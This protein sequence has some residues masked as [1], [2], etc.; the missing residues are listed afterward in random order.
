MRRVALFAFSLVGLFD[1]IYLWWAYSTPSRPLVCLG[2]GCDVVRASRFAYIRGVPLPLFGFAMYAALALLIF[3]EPLVSRALGSAVRLAVGVISGGGVLVSAYLTWVEA[4]VL[5]AWCFWCVISGVTIAGIFALAVLQVLRPPLEADFSAVV[6]TTRW[7]LAVFLLGM[8]AGVPGFR[9]LSRHE[10]PA[11]TALNTAALAERL[12]R[13]DSHAF[14]NPNA[15]LTVTEFADFECPYC[16]RA[17][18]AAAAVRKRFA[19]SV[20]FVFRQFPLGAIHPQAERAAEASECAAEQGKFW[21]AV[22]KLYAQQ[23]DLSEAALERYA[24]EL[25]LDSQRFNTCLASGRMAA[26][27]R[28]DREDALAIGVRATPT[29]FIGEREFEGPLEAAQF[30][31]LIEQELASRGV[32]VRA[33]GGSPGA[34]Q[35]SP[36]GGASTDP[37]GAGFSLAVTNPAG[38]FSQV[39]SS[40]LGCSEAE[41]K[42]QQP[43]LIHTA[44]ARQL[45]ESGPKALF[46]DVRSAKNFSAGRIP[47]AVSL[48]IEDLE[49]HWETLPKD[50]AIVI[51]ESGLSPG[52]VCASARAA[53]RLLLAHGYAQ[54]RVKVYQEGLAGWAKANLPIER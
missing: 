22:D 7:F 41:A 39:S 25:G 17:E 3:S 52:D 16:S 8:L 6:V 15:A 45:F 26:L 29:F 48:P 31:Q 36:R 50:R 34:P 14:G 12:V 21:E 51:Y 24:A 4:S 40:A 46:V 35:T 54:D 28:R 38:A 53:G 49:K 11:S 2:T 9:A 44:E 33:A 47:Q 42:K 13:P 1:S 27:V 32:A 18:Q 43:T 37:S 30:S 23:N 20:R 5:H 10:Q 19:G